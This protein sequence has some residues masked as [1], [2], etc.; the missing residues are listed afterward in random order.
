MNYQRY[1]KLAVII[2]L[3]LSIF[4]LSLGSAGCTGRSITG[5]NATEL[6][7][8]MVPPVE[9]DVYFYVKQENP[10]LVPGSL[11]G[12]ADDISVQSMVIWGV[13][14]DDSQYTL[15]GALNFSNSSDAGAV[16]AMI[17]ENTAIYTKLSESR[18]YF[19]RGE[20]NAVES[21]KNA[22]D[23]ND[24][25]LYN[26]N[27]ALEE[28]S[29]LPS[30]DT[31]KAAV[32]GVIKPD[33]SVVNLVKRYVGQNNASIIDSTFSDVKPTIMALGVYSPQPINLAELEQQISGRTA[34]DSDLGMA[35]SVN[36]VYPG[37]IF[38][39]VTRRVLGNK[40]FPEIQIGELSAYR[41]SVTVK[42]SQ[43]MPVYI[44]ISGNH[45]FAASAVKDSY[46]RDLL[47]GIS[48]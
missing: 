45:V 44:N 28:V 12:A 24:F 6:S 15:G 20:G 35:V 14:D 42:D 4:V 27:Q 25:K 36:S 1:V 26:D 21:I 48:R 40:D 30:G 11:V 5:E 17:P 33:Q 34:L 39:P 41:G 38:G 32:I 29:H 22:I 31:Y 43:V 19:V 7:A 46:A 47:S 3:V 18:V 2:S 23:T 8:F 37:V 16:F 10:T 13:V 9:L